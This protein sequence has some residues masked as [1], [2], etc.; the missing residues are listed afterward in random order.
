MQSQCYN[1]PVNLLV[2]TGASISLVN[3]RFIQH[4]NLSA[5]IK[6]TARLIAGLDKKIVPVQGEIS[7]PIT[8]GCVETKHTFVMCQHLE[9]EFLIGMDLLDI[10]QARI[11]I[12]NK[13]IITPVGESVYFDRPLSINKKYK[14]R[15]QK[16]IT[17]PANTTGY[18]PGKI[19]IQNCTSNYEGV[20]EGNHNLAKSKGIFITP[21][22]SYS[23][24]NIIP[25]H[26]VNT[27]P[28]DIT[29]TRN[30]L[31]AFIEPIS[32]NN[33]GTNISGIHHVKEEEL[34]NGGVTLTRLPDAESV[35]TFIEK[36]RWDNPAE[37]HKQLRIDEIKIPEKDKS[38]L[39]DLITEYSH[40]FSR[41]KYDLG[42]A[43]FYEAKIDLKPNYI[44]KWVPS[45]PISYKLEPYMDA[46]IENMIKSDQITNCPYSL[47]N[48]MV[49]LISKQ[50]PKGGSKFRFVQDGRALSSQ[51]IQDFYE[52]PRINS[53]FDRI[54]DCEW[55]SSFDFQSGFN[56]IGLEKLSQPLTAFTYKGKRYMSKRLIQGHVSSSASFSRCLNLLF[57]N[58]P[59]ES[60][61]LYVDDMMIW[62]RDIESHL[63]YIRILL[64]RLTWGGLKLSSLKSSMFLKSTKFLGHVISK[65]GI[66]IDENRI[67]AIQ[68]L[69]PPTSVK[70]LQK[71]IGIMNYNR[72]F[73]KGF[74][75]MTAPLYNLLRKGVKYE[76]TKECQESFDKLKSAISKTVTLSVPDI[77]DKLQSYH[78]VVD[79]SKKGQGATLSQ[80]INGKRRI[81][82]YWSRA[83]PKHQQKMGATRLE[84]LALH[85]ALKF[86]ELYLKGTRCTV[87][88]DCKALLSLE[89][90]FKNENSFFQRRLA[91]LAS[92][93]FEI[94]HISG[95][96]SD[97]KT[98][99]FLS[100]YNYNTSFKEN[101]TQTEELNN[102][103]S[104]KIFNVVHM[105]KTIPV[106]TADIK[107][108]Y[109]SDSILSVV[110]QWIKDGNRP[111]K[112]NHRSKPI[113]L[114]HYWK[115]FD[116]LKYE[117]G[118][119][120]RKWV[121]PNSNKIT[122]LIVVPCTLVERV[123][124]TFHDT[125]ATC[126]A[127]A[128]ACIA[129]CN[130]KFYFYNLK[131][132]FK[133]YIKSCIQCARA[134]QPLQYNR[135]AM[136]PSI[137]TEFNQAI[138]ID[139][140][141]PS[142]MKNKRG[143][144]AILTICD[145]Y[146]NY[147]VCVPVKSTGTVESVRAVLEHWILK[148]GV[149]EEIRHDL[150]TGF[151]SNLWKA[152]MKAFD[153]KDVKTTPKFSQS[154][155]KAEACNRKLNQCFRATLTENQW[156]DYDIYLKYIVFCL[157]SLE[158]SRTGFSPNYLVFNR[159]LRM[160][161]DLFINDNERL[162]STLLNDENLT[163][164][165]RNQAYGMYRQIAEITRKVRD[166]C[167]KRAKYMKK[168]Y[169]KH[170]Y[171]PTF[172]PGDWC[173]LLKLWGKHK[174]AEK[175]EGPFKVIERINSHNYVI[176][177]LGKNKVVNVSKMKV[178][179]PNKYF[180]PEILVQ[181]ENKPVKRKLT[182]KKKQLSSSSSSDDESY[183]VSFHDSN[184]AR[185]SPRLAERSETST[186]VNSNSE[187]VSDLNGRTVNE[188]SA[189][190]AIATDL[191]ENS[192]MSSTEPGVNTSGLSGVSDTE[193]S[194]ALDILD[195]TAT[196]A[197]SDNNS[198]IHDSHHAADTRPSTSSE[199]R[200]SDISFGEI[201]TD[202]SLSDIQ[203]YESV[204]SRGEMRSPTAKADSS[205]KGKRTNKRYNLRPK[206][207]TTKK[208]GFP[209]LSP[210]K[211][212]SK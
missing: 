180:N 51:S 118:I 50:N 112:F 211:K 27:M 79:S 115:N 11:D 173:F 18:L 139:H 148:H 83:V 43:S 98:A 159:E 67:K 198:E 130:K 56:Q 170:V 39:R 184:H 206:P 107:K 128:D 68:T 205:E 31:I 199:K 34:H 160:P 100:R 63:K 21:T 87:F 94:K 85:G 15:C 6:P 70:K 66:Q 77:S 12:P 145:M 81:I 30:Q 95:K 5:H 142:K 59:F 140:L 176:N 23:E 168:Q 8:I 132:E 61:I 119:L 143:I 178:F 16:T 114:C 44:A 146:S 144:C 53:I 197:I 156:N 99:D 45:R 162:K 10:L 190:S 3:T 110:I 91:D 212:K 86:W 84:L 166:K 25:V 78:V 29:I 181:D 117:N 49:Y 187:T 46:E 73:I 32:Y 65:D 54:S 75:E 93:N 161:R 123:L 4:N 37:L 186:G 108:E 82:A 154:N 201:N 80:I 35:E 203:D 28:N 48:S 33:T 105:D 177:V 113:E 2:D 149:P 134:K 157:N 22:L 92:F 90:I 204:R 13:K 9:N 104:N 38:S 153:I 194:D 116:L 172:A 52:L 19:A 102:Q 195:D 76:W 174:Y 209:F 155:G 158:S 62:S 138:S 192:Q 57:S 202:I 133:L 127:G 185:R 72:S 120:Y 103:K 74:A 17:I 131:K 193:F 141:E 69:Q 106:T 36:G 109:A 207:A 1:I 129:K 122:F 126:H 163:V 14:I 101:S 152:I 137:Y 150:G 60:I 58:L 135:A 97:M 41:N 111:D 147:L 26:I 64:E 20:I 167:E 96:S 191:A 47:W 182:P 189:Q 175:F 55:I 42:K 200:S 151:T 171:C 24:R 169:D 210:G 125:M 71:F 164:A 188:S 196:S 89:S 179:K 121:D 183:I 208:F 124:Y 7:L 88:T 40:C 165:A 136:K